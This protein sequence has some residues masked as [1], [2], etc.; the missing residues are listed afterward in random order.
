VVIGALTGTL[1]MSVLGLVVFRY[2]GPEIGHRNAAYFLGAGIALVT[3]ALGAVLARL[4]LRP[5]RGLER[6]AAQAR[7]PGRGVIARP[8]HFGTKELHKTA[9]SV[10]E[11]AET[12]RDREATVR[13]F[14]DHVTHEIKTPVT[15]IRAAVELLG[16]GREWSG[17]ERRLLD[18]I[19]G[20]GQQIEAQLGAL[21]AAATA[22]E[23]RHQGETTLDAVVAALGPADGLTLEV[24]G[25]AI[26]LPLSCDGVGIVLAQL[27]GNAREH[28]ASHVRLAARGGA[29]VAVRVEDN[30]SG[31]S[32]GNASR[33]FE[34]FFTTRRETG[35]T[36]MGLAIVRNLL[37]AHGAQIAHLPG[38]GEGAVFEITFARS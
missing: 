2:L 13:S 10:I 35:G 27:L 15:A 5:I 38:Q 16:D 20:A 22:R 31:V 8:R 17:T 4:L 6:Y 1:A 37:T 12:L 11:M 3:A 9:Q 30:G 23:T 18:D 14:T 34:P 24:E 28:G 33:I 29:A 25:G 19:D 36:G 21:R 26:V 32:Q 7:S